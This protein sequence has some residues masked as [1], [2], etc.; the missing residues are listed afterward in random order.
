MGKVIRFFNPCMPP[1]ESYGYKD[2]RK[3]PLF[4]PPPKKK[5]KKERMNEWVV[6]LSHPCT[7]FL[8]LVKCRR[9]ILVLMELKA[10]SLFKVL[11]GLICNTLLLFMSNIGDY[12]QTSYLTSLVLHDTLL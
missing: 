2:A 7:K 11:E 1:R 4:A 3:R 9:V 6:K 10:G 5:D 8:G 12:H